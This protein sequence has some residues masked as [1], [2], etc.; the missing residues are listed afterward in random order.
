MTSVAKFTAHPAAGKELV[1]RVFEDVFGE[2]VE[3]VK[4]LEERTLQNGETFEAVIFDGRRV[5]SF[6]QDK[7]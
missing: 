1:V 2:G 4:I 6:E 5:V 3:E 7:S